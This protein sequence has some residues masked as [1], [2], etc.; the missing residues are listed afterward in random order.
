MNRFNS[1]AWVA[2]IA[3]IFGCGDDAENELVENVEI[4]PP[5]PFD[6]VVLEGVDTSILSAPGDERRF[7]TLVGELLSPCGDPVS[8]Q[9][10][11]EQN[12]SCAR[13]RPAARYIARLVAAGAE[14]SDVRE[15][16]RARYDEDEIVEIP[17]DGAPV[18]GSLVG[19]PITVVEFSDFQCPYC[20]RAHP[21]LQRVAR[22]FE[23]QVRVVFKNYPLPS[24]QFAQGAARASL[25]AHRQGKFWQ[26]H[27]MMFDNQTE[28]A[29][30]DLEG[31]A[32]RIGLDMDRFRVD[33]ESEELNDLVETSRAEGREVGVQGTPSIFVNGRRFEED[34]EFLPF[35]IQ[36]ELDG[37][38]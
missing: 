7:A 13:C 32:R 29:P 24:H 14:P 22:Q 18:R 36:E 1:I 10:C 33:M 38:D 16:Y 11:V 21:V 25:A 20:G 35:Y 4:T 8:V 9:A 2:A 19:A 31:Y 34:F 6:P 12:A 5:E 37:L 15:L 28:L 30:S 26:M 23:G 3:I 27:D 17:I